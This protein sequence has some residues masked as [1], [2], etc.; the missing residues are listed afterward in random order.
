MG[1]KEPAPVFGVVS[2]SYIQF[3]VADMW[4]D[5]LLITEML[6]NALEKIFQFQP[7]L[8][9]RGNH[10]GSPAPTFWENAVFPILA[11]LYDGLFFGLLKHCQIFFGHFFLG[12]C[13]PID[14]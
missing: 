11:N 9:P 2:R 8:S 6:L 5:N 12:K 4:T 14:T 13:D 7:E 1:R 3:L 10:R